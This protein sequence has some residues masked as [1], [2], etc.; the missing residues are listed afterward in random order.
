MDQASKRSSWWAAAACA[1][2]LGACGGGG[3]G[4]GTRTTTAPATGAAP[5]P[6]DGSWFTMVPSPVMLAGYVGIPAPFTVTGRSTSTFAQPANILVVDPNNILAPNVAV[7]ASPNQTYDIALKTASNI[8]VGT[9]STNAEVR[10]CEDDPHTCARPFPGSPWHLP[11]T[12]G[13]SARV[14]EAV[15]RGVAIRAGQTD[16][17]AYEGEEIPVYL[18]LV[19]APDATPGYILIS[20]TRE[21]PAFSPDVPVAPGGSYDATVVLKGIPKAGVY[22]T[23]LNFLARNK[24][25]SNPVYAA[26][27]DGTIMVIPLLINVRAKQ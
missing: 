7:T 22:T 2:L 25:G 26:K 5:P 23:N 24:D 19:A 21:N 15:V 6:A 9:Y 3:G 17:T 1:L 16:L 4:G 12:L 14:D 10:I 27:P 13:V 11:I 18:K 8:P 20:A